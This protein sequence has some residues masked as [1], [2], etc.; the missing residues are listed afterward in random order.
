[1]KRVSSR[2]ICSTCRSTTLW[3]FSGVSTLSSHWGSVRL[4]GPLPPTTGPSPNQMISPRSPWVPASYAHSGRLM[5]CCH[6][7]LIPATIYVSIHFLD[8]CCPLPLLK[9]LYHVPLFY[10]NVEMS[11]DK[12]FDPFRIE[13]KPGHSG[14]LQFPLWLREGAV[15]LRIIVQRSRPQLLNKGYSITN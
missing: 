2:G 6:S 7:G 13:K 15:D 9:W 14:W 8:F 4:L 3:L 5:S 11:L 12:L 1:M 10:P